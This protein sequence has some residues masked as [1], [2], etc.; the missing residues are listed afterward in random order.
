MKSGCV[1]CWQG[2]PAGFA[3][4]V[5]DAVTAI[6]DWEAAGL[7]EHAMAILADFHTHTWFSM[8]LLP[9]VTSTRKGCTA[10]SSVA[11]LI[12]I[13]P[14]ALL[15]RRL[16][17]TLREE[18]LAYEVDDGEA[19]QLLD[20][21]GTHEMHQLA[22]IAY[23]DDG[24]IPIVSPAH[25]IVSSLRRAAS[26]AWFTSTTH[27][28]GL[29]F[30]PG[31]SEAIIAFHGEGSQ[32]AR[33]HVFSERGGVLVCDGLG[34][35]T[36]ELR[37]V[38]R[39][40]HLGGLISASGDLGNEVCQKMALVRQTSRQLKR[41]FLRDPKV[42]LQRKGQVIQ[43]LVLSRGLHLAGCWPSLLP[44][45]ARA[46]KR[47]LVDTLR[48]LVPHVS[49]I[50][51][52]SDD[53]ILS[54]LG[55]LHPQRLLSLL[56]VQLAIRV[57]QRAPMQVL[58]LI[59]ASRS[60]KRSWLN[61]LEADLAHIGHAST[62]SEMRRTPLANWFGF[63]RSF[64]WQAKKIVLRA[65]VATNW[66]SASERDAEVVFTTY[67]TVCGAAC[68]DMQALSV[69][70]F[71][72]HGVRR[73]I[74]ALVEGHDCLVCGLRFASRQR[75]ID[76]LAEQGRVCAHNYVL[77]YRPLSPDSLAVLEREGRAEF[78]RRAR[79]DGAH[80]VRAHGPFLPVRAL[81]GTIICSRHPLG[82]NR[83]WSGELLL[84]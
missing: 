7:S 59:V 23:V 65:V 68:R 34:A 80:G 9:G 69:H 41:T 76:H 66:I 57:A 72:S 33:R 46:M 18:G 60:A 6:C 45:E 36:F 3:C 73:A 82:P 15:A 84:A 38:A 1:S 74:R 58:A 52:L 32:A 21:P 63:F 43:A 50:R 61:A 49:D 42:P 24:V 81:G 77:R 54:R 53:C 64:P 75:I 11:Y 78:S 14:D 26:V 20:I 4:E 40:R 47:A 17:Q 37:V 83:R 39:Y 48:P 29:N 5:V 55:V 13:A 22:R 51:K 70:T 8:E 35:S 71:R 28:L 56:R 12:Y 67:C 62:L 10:G 2:F 30:A 25:Q 16:H 27:G 79:L 44:R 31:K 19:R